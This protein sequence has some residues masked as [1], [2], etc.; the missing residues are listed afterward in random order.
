MP[1]TSFRNLLAQNDLPQSFMYLAPILPIVQVMWADNRNQMPEREKVQL[2]LENHCLALTEMFDG[3]E[4]VS[5]ADREKFVAMFVSV[6]PDRDLLNHFAEIAVQLVVEKQPVQA[7]GDG[8]LNNP[9][10]LIT[11]CMEIAAACAIHYP[12]PGN[13]LTQKRILDQERVLI[14]KVIGLLIKEA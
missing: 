2:L 1:A 3:V 8:S 12:A 7:D 10:R 14:V 6:K 4:P 9:D 13:E 5:K 11:A